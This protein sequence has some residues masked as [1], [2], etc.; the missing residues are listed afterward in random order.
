MF[1]LGCVVKKYH[2]SCLHTPACQSDFVQCKAGSE[3]KEKFLTAL[4]QLSHPVSGRSPKSKLD[5]RQ[6]SSKGSPKRVKDA[7]NRF[8]LVARGL[9][10]SGFGYGATGV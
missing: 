6:R 3:T 9:E 1:C 2:D 10:G 4:S 7:A 8:V 5:G